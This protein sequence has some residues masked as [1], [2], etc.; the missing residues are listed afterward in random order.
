[1][2]WVF[3]GGVLFGGFLVVVVGVCF[4]L[5]LNTALP[6]CTQVRSSLNTDW[7]EWGREWEEFGGGCDAIMQS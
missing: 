6:I 1:M 2:F 5:F 4:V 3:F 7:G